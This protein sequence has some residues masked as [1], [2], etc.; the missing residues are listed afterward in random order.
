MGCSKSSS[1]REIH[2][3]ICLLQET[4]NLNNLTLYLKKLE[5]EQM[6]L[7]VIRRKEI[8]KIRAEVNET[9][10]KKQQKNINETKSCFF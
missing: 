9:E 4:K 1:K 6:K 5:K 10:T 8:T 7:K 2:L 3:N